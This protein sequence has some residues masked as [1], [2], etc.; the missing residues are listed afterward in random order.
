MS[1]RTFEELTKL[2]DYVLDTEAKIEV[3][4][5]EIKFLLHC[6]TYEF[7]VGVMFGVLLGLIAGILLVVSGLIPH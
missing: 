7:I 2:S 5:E 3:T 1:K 6:S 4:K